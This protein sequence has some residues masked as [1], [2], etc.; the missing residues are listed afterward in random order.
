M[1]SDDLAALRAELRRLYLAAGC[2]RWEAHDVVGGHVHLYAIDAAGRAWLVAMPNK[3]ADAQLAAAA[4]N[5]LPLLFAEI[6][7]LR[8][9]L[10]VPV[11][12]DVV[13]GG[14]VVWRSRAA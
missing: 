5:A 2:V 13:D 8:A 1:P 3:L 6:D 14:R 11:L 7:R 4:R 9:R 12:G 10:G